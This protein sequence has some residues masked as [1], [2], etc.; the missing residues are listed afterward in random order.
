MFMSRYGTAGSAQHSSASFKTQNCRSQAGHTSPLTASASFGGLLFTPDG[1][2]GWQQAVVPGCIPCISR[3]VSALSQQ[4]SEILNSSKTCDP[5]PASPVQHTG[6]YREGKVT[7]V[8]DLKPLSVMQC[9]HSHALV[10][11]PK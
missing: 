3:K 9:E 8:P 4:L 5:M 6:C 1:V 11:L 7:G 2:M 10:L